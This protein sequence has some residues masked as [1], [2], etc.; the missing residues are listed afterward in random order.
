M[1]K[2]D[3]FSCRTPGQFL[4]DICHC[5]DGN[6]CGTE[7]EY[8]QRT[9]LG[10]LSKLKINTFASLVKKRTVKL[11]NEKVLTIN[12]DHELFG[13]LVIASISRDIHLKDVLSYDLSAIPFSLVHTDGSWR[14]RNKSILMAEPGKM[15]DVQLKQQETTTSAQ[16]FDTTALVHY[17]NVI[18]R[19]ILW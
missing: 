7:T 5:S 1:F 14:K 3:V 9:V 2:D 8:Q 6:V 4:R 19:I 15:V 18:W 16:T 11:V 10:F 12:A 17:D 13:R